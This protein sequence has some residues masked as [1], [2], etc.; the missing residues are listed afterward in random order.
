MTSKDLIK[1]QAE[2]WVSNKTVKR[3]YA[4]QSVESLEKALANLKK[5]EQRYMKAYGAGL[6]S[7]EQLQDLLG[8]LK[9]KITSVESQINELKEQD[10]DIEVKIP[11]TELVDQFVKKAIEMLPKLTFDT[12]QAIVRKLVDKI[13]ANQQELTVHGYLPLGKEEKYV[14]FWAIGRNCWVAKCWEVNVI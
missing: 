5:E 9:A 14:K 12:R 4:D 3:V 2:R 1:K 7:I 13:V 8:G 11:T 10:R 6:M